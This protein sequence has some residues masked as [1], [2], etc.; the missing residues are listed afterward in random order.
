MMNDDGQTMERFMSQKQ[1]SQDFIV[2]VHR[3]IDSNVEVP[4]SAPSVKEARH[5]AQ[6]AMKQDQFQPHDDDLVRDHV[7]SVKKI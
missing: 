5:K 3:S 1:Q 2:D 6:E 7:I 4:V